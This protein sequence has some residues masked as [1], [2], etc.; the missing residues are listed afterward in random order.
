MM[1]EDDTELLIYQ[2]EE[3]S[4]DLDYL[5][6]HVKEFQIRKW[7]N[8]ILCSL[9][10]LFSYFHRNTTAV[11]ADDM[12]NAFHVKKTAIGIFASLF[13][14]T[15]GLMQPIVGSLA[16]AIEPGFIIAISNLITT[17][18]SFIISSSTNLETA[19]V[20]R[21][22]LGIGC[23]AIFVCTTKVGANWF[24]DSGYRLFTGSLIGIGS[25]G[26]ILSQAPL[27][28]IGKILGW[29]NVMKLIG[30]ISFVLGF[31][32]ALFVRGH[33]LDIGFVG[34]KPVFPKKNK[35][36]ASI[37]TNL[38]IMVTNTN[39]WILEIFMFC[40][41]GVFIDIASLWGIPY[42]VDVLGF[43]KETASKAAMSLSLSIVIG[44]PVIPAIAEKTN[45]RKKTMVVFAIISTACCFAM[46]FIGHYLSFY[47]IVVIYFVIGWGL[48][49]SQ[50]IALSLFKDYASPSMAATMTG[51][52]NTGPA[53]GG[54]L[55]QMLTSFII[56][57]WPGSD[58]YPL[59]A[60]KVGLWGT[61]FVVSLIG[62]AS[63]CFA[64]EVNKKEDEFEQ[65]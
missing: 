20:G 60:Y 17:I 44:S 46:I 10:Y 11:L 35:K 8:I 52:G 25:I 9:S 7:V 24:T 31:L 64:A 2:P 30:L 14:W 26:A 39:F 56:Q 53:V 19:C 47:E 42:L 37:C 33:P 29:R 32:S 16:D 36:K 23:S 3:T 51:G 5:Q 41:P 21:F 43:S 1:N 15:Y 22:L 54:A 45:A 4:H 38:Y 65:K 18:G 61:G 62:T 34:E 50:G 63:L 27:Q 49:A 48:S 40:C 55:I 6:Y 13:F 58:V 28:A 57:I 59:A 12:A